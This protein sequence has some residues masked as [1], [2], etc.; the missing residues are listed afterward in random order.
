[1]TAVAEPAAHA[2][3]ESVPRL[4]EREW[5]VLEGIASGLSN[6]EIGGVLFV[7][8]D[9]VKTHVR[10]LFKKLDARDRANAVAIGIRSG[11]LDE[12]PRRQGRAPKALPSAHLLMRASEALAMA[13]QVERGDGKIDLAAN[14]DDTASRLR[15]LVSR[16]RGEL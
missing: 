15:R 10:R 2:V 16:A 11:L 1:M 14:L 5:Q 13:A 3:D 4:T 9:T 12:P 7:S 8:E 6:R